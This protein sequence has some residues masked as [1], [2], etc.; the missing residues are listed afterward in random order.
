MVFGAERVRAKRGEACCELDLE[1]GCLRMIHDCV[2]DSVLAA[3]PSFLRLS[4]A[5]F[6]FDVACHSQ[7]R[8]WEFR[9]PMLPLL[10]RGFWCFFFPC[11]MGLRAVSGVLLTHFQS[12]PLTEALALPGFSSQGAV[13]GLREK[14]SNAF[15]SKTGLKPQ[16]GKPEASRT[17]KMRATRSECGLTRGSQ[18]GF[19]SIGGRVK[20]N[21]RRIDSRPK[22][23]VLLD[24]AWDLWG[25]EARNAADRRN[26][27]S[28]SAFHA[29]CK[30]S[31]Y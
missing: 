28:M 1:H 12:I 30:H 21:P 7:N 31:R 27:L 2:G 17:S 29:V 15:Q 13:Q 23:H 24:S 20:G 16:K 6:A 11:Q 19:V 25:E 5:T 14:P 18:L 4:E 3:C 8:T 9:S 22:E 10:P 26:E